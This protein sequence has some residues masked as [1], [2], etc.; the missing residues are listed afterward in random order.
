MH[1]CLPIDLSVSLPSC[2]SLSPL[3]VVS[4]CPPVCLCPTIY[5]PIFHL[6]CCLLCLPDHLFVCQLPIMADILYTLSLYH[7]T[8]QPVLPSPLYVSFCYFCLVCLPI[9]VLCQCFYHPFSYPV[10]FLSSALQ[11]FHVR[12]LNGLMKLHINR[13]KVFP[14]P[15]LKRQLSRRTMGK[16][17][18]TPSHLF[19]LEATFWSHNLGRAFS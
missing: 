18:Q 10:F 9:P 15:Y 2:C 1:F 14:Y 16:S 6:V 12:P 8:R 17:K 5:L 3:L 11:S 7:F 19:L 13:T 4:I